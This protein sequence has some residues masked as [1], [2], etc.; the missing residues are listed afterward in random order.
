MF[1]EDHQIWCHTL[2]KICKKCLWVF[3]CS[4]LGKDTSECHPGPGKTQEVH[5]Y[6]CCRCNITEIMLKAV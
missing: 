3:R 1:T 4:V 2:V 5:E 6:V